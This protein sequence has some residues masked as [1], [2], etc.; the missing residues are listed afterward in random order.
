MLAVYIRDVAEKTRESVLKVREELR[1][2]GV[3]MEL[4]PDTEAAAIHAADHGWIPKSRIT[5]VRQDIARDQ[6]RQE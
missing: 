6:D 3:E 1:A 4:V 2:A 5:D